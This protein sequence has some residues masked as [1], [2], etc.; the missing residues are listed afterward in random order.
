LAELCTLCLRTESGDKFCPSSKQALADFLLGANAKNMANQLSAQLAAMV[1]NVNHFIS[2]DRLVYAPCLTD[3]GFSS[4]FITI[5]D[6]IAAAADEL[7][8]HGETFVGSPFRDYQECLKD[9]LDRANNNKGCVK[10]NCDCPATF[11]D[12]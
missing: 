8:A 6:L 4:P 10:P 7:C 12:A 11:D 1:L 2:G 5:D 3:F 9:T